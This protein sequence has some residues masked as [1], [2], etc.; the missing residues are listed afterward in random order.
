MIL[1][2]FGIHAEMRSVRV[3]EEF[4][5]CSISSENGGYAIRIIRRSH[6]LRET[7]FDYKK[8]WFWEI[9]KDAKGKYR[10]RASDSTMKVRE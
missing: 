6:L 3:P 2:N 8:R 10:W 1:D 5:L 9:C 4:E 7:G